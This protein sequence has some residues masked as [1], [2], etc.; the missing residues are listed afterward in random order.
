ME[1]LGILFAEHEIPF[2]AREQRIMC[3][4]HVI[5]I[6]VQHV[7]SKLSSSLPPEADEDEDDDEVPAN[8]KTHTDPISRC[9][10]IIAKIRSSGQRHE[11][12]ESWITTGEPSC[13][14]FNNTYKLTI[15][16]DHGWFKVGDK[17]ITIP[18]K[19]LLRDVRT[20]WDSTYLMLKRFIEMRPVNF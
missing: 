17:V 14:S 19:Q 7:I 15:G 20:R 3:I 1:E 16:N 2:N 10:A 9:R 18:H 8:T 6:I 11:K 12:F 4:P 5:N 13:I